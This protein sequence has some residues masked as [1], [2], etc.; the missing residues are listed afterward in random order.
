MKLFNRWSMDAKVSDPSLKPYINLKP[1]LV[2]R[3]A[4]R[5]AKK[6]LSKG[7][8]SL[9][10]R[11]INKLAISGHRGKEH[12]ISSGENVGK[13]TKLVKYLINTFEI[14]EQ[15]GK[16]PI[17]VL[18]D[19]V[20]NSAPLEE[21]T[22]FRQG[23]IIVHKAVVTSPQRR[24]D[25]ALRFIVQ[26]TKDRAFDKKVSISEALANELLDAA[27]NNPKCYAIKKRNEKEKLAEAAR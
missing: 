20:Q 19:A 21:I 9:V 3:T 14:I 15:Q 18:V 25:L 11:L 27:A 13:W 2:P 10:E 7:E 16:N 12:K 1:V 24:V 17:Q 22:S 5:L 6:R 8:I 23:G 4:G 26:G